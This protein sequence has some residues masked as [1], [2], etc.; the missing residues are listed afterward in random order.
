MYYPREN[1]KKRTFKHP[2]STHNRTQA[3][4]NKIKH[5]CAPTNSNAGGCSALITLGFLF[6]F[7]F[8]YLFIFVF[9]AVLPALPSSQQSSYSWNMQWETLCIAGVWLRTCATILIHPSVSSPYS[10]SNCAFLIFALFFISF[11]PSFKHSLASHV[12]HGIIHHNTHTAHRNIQ[13]HP[14]IYIDW[15]QKQGCVGENCFLRNI[16]LLF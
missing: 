14:Q 9:F 10:L 12:Q 7:L 13:P 3:T 8:I 1:A 16:N 4:R 15:A 5:S 2:H 6:S 11:R